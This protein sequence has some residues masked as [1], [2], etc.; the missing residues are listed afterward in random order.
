MEILKECNEMVL[1]LKRQGFKFIIQV[2][3]ENIK[4][5]DDVK[6]QLSLVEYIVYAGPRIG[7]TAMKGYV[8]SYLLKKIIY[9][10]KNIV[11]GVVIK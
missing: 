11:E 5:Y 10:D 2:T 3:S 8:P 6:K 9:V 4:L 1:K 7:K